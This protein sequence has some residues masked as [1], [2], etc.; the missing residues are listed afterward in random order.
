VFRWFGWVSGYVFLDDG[1]DALGNPVGAAGNGI[2]DC[3]DPALLSTCERPLPQTDLD[4][5]FRD[6]SVKQATFTDVNGYYEFPESR[7]P[8]GR[9]E[10]AEVGFGRFATSGHSLHNEHYSNHPDQFTDSV[11]VLPSD[12]GG[13][14]LL[15]QLSWE[16]RRTIIDWGK[17]PWVGT[18]NGGITGIVDYAVTATADA[19]LPRR[20]LRAGHPRTAASAD[21]ALTPSSTTRR[22]H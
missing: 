9:T 8:L 22:L 18:E 21:L 3:A 17:R 4:I 6:G 15:S 19:S 12:L 7:S 1:F 16:G 20:G 13:D 5:R 14:L 11:T 10:I 2:R